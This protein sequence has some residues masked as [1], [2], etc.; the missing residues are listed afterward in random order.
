MGFQYPAALADCQS[1]VRLEVMSLP[2]DI[3]HTRPIFSSA[4]PLDLYWLC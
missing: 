1:H 3:S 2:M 4:V